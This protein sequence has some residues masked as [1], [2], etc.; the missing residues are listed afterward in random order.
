MLPGGKIGSAAA[1]FDREVSVA[2]KSD[3]VETATN[4]LDFICIISSNLVEI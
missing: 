2:R 4:R 3:K 1:N